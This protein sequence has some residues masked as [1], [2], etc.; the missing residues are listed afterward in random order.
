MPP[1]GTED[2]I[3]PSHFLDG[4]VTIALLSLQTPL[5]SFWTD[6]EI[7]ACLPIS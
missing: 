3:E 2:F 1:D 4:A 5:V 7:D 6:G